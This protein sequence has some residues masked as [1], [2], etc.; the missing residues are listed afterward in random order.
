M[1]A[2]M[3]RMP[4]VVCKKEAQVHPLTRW[5]GRNA[6]RRTMI[7]TPT[8]AA[9]SH[10]LRLISD[11]SSAVMPTVVLV[12]H[13]RAHIA[14]LQV[15]AQRARAAVPVTHGRAIVPPQYQRHAALVSRSRKN[16]TSTLRTL[17]CILSIV[18]Q[19]RQRYAYED[20][21]MYQR[22]LLHMRPCLGRFNSNPEA[23]TRKYQ[24][25]DADP[26]FQHGPTQRKR[27]AN[28]SDCP[29][30]SAKKI[31]TGQNPCCVQCDCSFDPSA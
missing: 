12:P 29:W 22:R 3:N 11:H 16:Q 21:L 4:R 23:A 6:K 24:R 5:C 7:L 1:T 26:G 2:L 15:H 9:P 20:T 19:S 13:L 17:A 30:F 8:S 25:P 28:R 27:S 18:S 14:A 31:A 10:Y